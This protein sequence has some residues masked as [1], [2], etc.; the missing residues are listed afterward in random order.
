M[1]LEPSFPTIA[2]VNSNGAIVHYRA[3]PGS[4]KEVGRDD[5][6][7]LDSGGQYL[8]GT[9]DVT[10]TFHTGTPTPLQR[11]MFTRV[12]KGHIGV[13]SRVFIQGTAGCQLD[14]YAREHLWAIG[15]DYIHGTGH[16]VG[17]ALNVHEGP[18]SISRVLNGCPLTP[19]MVVSNEPGYYEAGKYGIRIENLLVVV[20][21]AELGEFGGRA[22]YGFERLTHIPIQKRLMDVS[23][24]TDTEVA[25]VDTYHR[26]VRERVEPLMRTDRG[27][28]WLEASTSPLRDSGSGSGSSSTAAGSGSSS[29]AVAPNSFTG[30]GSSSQPAATGASDKGAATTNK[31]FY[32]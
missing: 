11:E 13:D 1:F 15:K 14:S 20:E 7:L 21:K 28:R 5:M 17:A 22:F 31:R 12:L 24:L 30:F 19:G 23:L 9:T 18:H 29:S 32:F 3:V 26:Q 2:G 6:V 27:R 4:A 16:G 8:D 25:W 10:R